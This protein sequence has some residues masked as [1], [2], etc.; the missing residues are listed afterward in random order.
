MNKFYAEDHKNEVVKNFIKKNFCEIFEMKAKTTV[1]IIY[2]FCTARD[3]KS[4]FVKRKA[5]N[6]KLLKLMQ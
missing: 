4:L 6:K 3:E 2:L 1:C 5:Q